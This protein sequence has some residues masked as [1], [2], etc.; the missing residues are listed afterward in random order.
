VPE[1]TRITVSKGKLHVTGDIGAKAK[2]EVTVPLAGYRDSYTCTM[3]VGK[4]VVPSTCYRTIFT[5]L[6]YPADRDPA[7][8]I[9][10]S[11]G[12]KAKVESNAGVTAACSASN[13]KLK[14]AWGRDIVIPKIDT[15]R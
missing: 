15:C 7:I 13:A 6:A 11:I 1:G 12:T 9:D 2:V 5:G 3:L 10:G 8:R 4:V 14:T